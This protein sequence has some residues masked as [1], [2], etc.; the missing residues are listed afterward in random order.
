MV[1]TPCKASIILL[2]F[3]VRPQYIYRTDC[4][5]GEGDRGAGTGGEPVRLVT[6]R[7]EGREEAAIVSPGGPLPVREINGFREDETSDLL[8]LL[9][10]GRFYE[11]KSLY[12]R[13]EVK[14]EPV[15]LDKYEY[16]PLYRR[17]RKIWGIGLNYVEH[18][19]DLEETAPS[20]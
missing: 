14:G 17:P 16:G 13:G 8:S 1:Q 12:D 15:S 18:A 5:D 11:L 20:E 6:I 3:L 7:I 19:G 4:Y 2:P 10:S 9:E